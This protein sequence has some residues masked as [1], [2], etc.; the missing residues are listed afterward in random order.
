MID[1]ARSDEARVELHWLPLGAGDG[2]RC[3]A[4]SGRAFEAIS[5]RHQGRPRFDLYHSALIVYSDG[6]AHTIEMAP[7]WTGTGNRGVVGTGPVGLPGLGRSRWFR[8]EIRRWLDGT[9]P[10]LGQ[11]RGS[12]VDVATDPARAGRLLQLAPDFPTAT[13]GR[14]EQGAGEMW[15]SNSLISW[16]L[17]SSDHDLSAARVPARGRA[18]GWDAGV[19][20]AMR[21][22][23]QHQVSP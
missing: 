16:L 22:L 13:W 20:V 9:I 11:E 23:V 7:E 17:V 5:A 21:R 1:S 2:A 18:P 8:Y 14:D 12:P 6:A 19:V 4:W 15:N 10:D 3:V